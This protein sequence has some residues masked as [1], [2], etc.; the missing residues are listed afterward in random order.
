MSKTIDDFRNFFKPDKQKGSFNAMR[1]VG[2]VL[3]LV[4]AQLSSNKINFCLTCHTHHKIYNTM[5]SMNAIPSCDAMVIAGYRNEFRHVIINLLS[6]AQDAILTR[7]KNSSNPSKTPGQIDIDFYHTDNTI[8]I[9][10]TD[11]GAGMDAK[12]LGQVFAPYFTTKGPDQGTGMGLYMSKM[13]IEHMDGTLSA[14]NTDQGAV[15]TIEMPGQK[16]T[17]E[18]LEA[19][20]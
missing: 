6:N 14:H 2:E 17:A 20:D 11:N 1:V 18:S 9:K 10:I 12:T 7:W 15:F 13:I 19:A 5:D 16:G 4:A 8:T 3:Q